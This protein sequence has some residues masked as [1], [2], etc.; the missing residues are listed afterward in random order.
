MLSL[1]TW[2]VVIP[3]II[4][5]LLWYLNEVSKRKWELYARKEERYKQLLISLKGFYDATQDTA[6]KA[7]FLEELNL[8]WLYSPDEVIRKAYAFLDTVKVG[9]DTTPKEKADAA[10]DLALAVRKDILPRPLWKLGRKTKLAPS[11]FKHL[12]TT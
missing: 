7:A 1:E 4:A 10:G 11:D 6:Q 3:L 9:A 12:H 5:I 8:C 2:T